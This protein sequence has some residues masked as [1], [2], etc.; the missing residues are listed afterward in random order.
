MPNWCN[1]FVEIGHED[2][3]KIT[4]LSEAFKRGEFCQHVIPTPK[5]LTETVAGFMG[6]DQR[7][8]HEAQQKA[9]LEK[10]GH[11]DWYSFQTS[12]WGTK[13]DVGG[14]DGSCDV[15]PD[16]KLM[17]AGFDSAWAPP[18][19]VY[20]E[21]V[22][23]GYTVRAYYYEPGMA[24]AGIWDNGDDDCYQDWGNSKQA[25]ETLPEDLDEMFGISE[26]QEEWE[27]ENEEELTQWI[28]E[29]AEAKNGTAA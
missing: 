15:H 2:A 27:R 6:E 10:Y 9:N 24:F 23:Q 26:S 14:D 1:N 5:E 21:L 20:E 17:T 13:W 16:G 4:A 19:G 28:R 25:R 22:E 11:T 7:A 3:D 8:A 18:I 12:R 29:G